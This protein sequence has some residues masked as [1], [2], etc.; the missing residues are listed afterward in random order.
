MSYYLGIDS[1]TTA[2]KALLMDA[3]GAVVGVAS[4]EYSFET[5]HPLWSEQDPALWWQAAQE[6]IQAVLAKTGVAGD[7]V[8][9]IGLT[10]QMHGLVLLDRDGQVLRPAILWNDQRTGSQCDTIRARLGKDNLIRITGNDALTGFTAPKILWVQ[11]QE[12][13][14]YARV[15]HILLPKDYVRLQLTGEYATDRAGG[16]G[17]ILFDIRQRT[18]S[19]Q[20]LAALG[21]D[22][23]W[24][25]PTFEGTEITGRLTAQAAQ[26]TGLVAGI[27]VVGGGGDQAAAAVGTGA[28]QEGIIS[29]SM[30]TSGV[31]FATMDKATI[32]PQGRLHAFCHAVPGK[33]HLMG[34][35][36]SAAGSLRWHRDTF[37]PGADYNELT[38]PAASIP[39]G[40][41]GLLFLP[42]LTG[43]RTPHPDPLA[44]GGFIG[45][46]VRHNLAHLTRAVLEGVA[47]GLRDSFELIKA[48]GLS[49]I[50]QVRV[51]GG[52]ARS[53]LWLQIL[54][55]V[56]NVEL[57]TMQSEEGA[58]QGAAL[59]AATGTGAFTDVASACQQALHTTGH[60][61]P[62]PE[63][64]VYENLYP[65]Y[66]GLYP[67]L[68][69]TFQ[70]LG[71][72][73]S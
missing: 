41:D 15:A 54:A 6:S 51:T 19:P 36:L 50:S 30:G 44:R 34:V 16:A 24:L 18:W 20:V 8:G 42:Y 29:L 69:S 33:W 40:S 3:Q 57:F 10:G 46:T 62:G 61:A 73:M 2:T 65:L 12:P 37:A 1:S 64:Q 28:V 55:D 47:F 66:Q 22:L 17:T 31:V 38:A 11:E 72:G 63:A 56:L 26:A 59:L 48:V 45:L 23:A 52:G 67:A 13:A 53:Q 21:I 14:I 25:P 70:S 60:T 5:P 43:E 27:P 35:M 71:A 32:E 49:G 68:Q 39:A 58:A 4:S 9:G 7:Q